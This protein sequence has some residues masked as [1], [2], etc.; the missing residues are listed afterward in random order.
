MTP[1]L[2]T[3][4]WSQ[5]D[6][7]SFAHRLAEGGYGAAGARLTALM[8][9][10]KESAHE[11]PVP[12]SAPEPNW[13]AGVAFPASWQP[14]WKAGW[15]GA[16]DRPRHFLATQIVVLRVGHVPVAATAIFL[17]HVQPVDD[18]PGVTPAP[19]A[20]EILFKAVRAGLESEHVGEARA[21]SL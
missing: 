8:E 21:P 1:Q 19:R 14:A 5:Y 13:G 12:Q 4:E 2:G 7:I 9:E 10:P 20:L 6:A 18:N 17:P 11:L 16:R 3:A 15:G